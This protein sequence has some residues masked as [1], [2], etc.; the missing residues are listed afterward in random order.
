MNQ[1]ALERPHYA[2]ELLDTAHAALLRLHDLDAPSS[3][4]QAL[5]IVENERQ[6]LLE[7]LRHEAPSGFAAAWMSCTS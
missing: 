6:Q 3:I 2:L 1:D 4:T 5:R 7:V